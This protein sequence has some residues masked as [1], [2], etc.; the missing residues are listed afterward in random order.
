MFDMLVL[1]FQTDSTRVATMLLAHDGSNRSFEH[2]GIVEGHHDL[3]HHQNRKDWIEKVADIDLFYARQFGRFLEKLQEIKDLD[4]N[5]LLHN[6]MIV[7]GSGNADANRHTHDN[8]PFVLAGG[9]GGTLNAGR[10]TKNGSK[11]VTNL[12]LSMADRIGIQGLDHF[13][14]STGR[15]ETIA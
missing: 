14:D 13:G 2:I 3:S 7:Y 4:G 10:Y 11:P 15:L 6:S 9:G 8:L 5:S 1:A 12:F